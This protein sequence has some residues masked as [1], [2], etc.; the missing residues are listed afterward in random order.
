MGDTPSWP[1]RLRDPIPVVMVR[2]HKI[3]HDVLVVGC[4]LLGVE[5]DR[6]KSSV[7]RHTCLTLGHDASND[8][9]SLMVAC[10]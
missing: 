3:R 5:R 1:R 4:W 10:D 2:C 7:F 9:P 8:V 6:S